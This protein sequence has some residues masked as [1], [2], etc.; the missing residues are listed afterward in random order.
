MLRGLGA[1]PPGFSTRWDGTQRPPRG[2]G[3]RA[4]TA[5]G[6]WLI[7]G[8]DALAAQVPGA[9][10]STPDADRRA[11]Q[12][13]FTQASEAGKPVAGIVWRSAGEPGA[14]VSTD[15]LA[16]RLETRVDSMLGAAQTALAEDTLNLPAACGRRRASG[17]MRTGRA[18]RPG[19]HR[20]VGIGR[21]LIAEQ[22]TL[23]C[24]LV[25]VTPPD[26]A[27]AWLADA[28]R[29]A[30]RRAGVAV[31]QGKFLVPRLLHWARSGQLPMPRS[32]DYALAPDRAGAIDNLRPTESV[33][34]PPSPDEVQVRVEAAGLNFRDILNVLGLYPGDPGPIGGDLCGVV[35][36]VG[37]RGH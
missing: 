8:F 29:H 2:G 19:E 18:G 21:T 4:G 33:V 35:T 10:H 1:T 27:A 28:L 23:R 37:F 11:W 31:R 15:V 22:P 36:D 7:A 5:D 9:S 16:S 17:G 3:Q 25:D 30:R 20:P 34:L 6:T 12:Q 32:A 13:A 24:R 26:S 14:E